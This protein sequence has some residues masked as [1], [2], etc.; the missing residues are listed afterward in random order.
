[1]F[2]NSPF[3]VATLYK[4][5]LLVE[6]DCL[7]VL[8]TF[9]GVFI[10]LLQLLSTVESNF[11]FFFFSSFERLVFRFFASFVLRYFVA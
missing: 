1:M 2:K 10:V 9:A 4:G 3:S 5:K 7:V 6:A 8:E 11:A